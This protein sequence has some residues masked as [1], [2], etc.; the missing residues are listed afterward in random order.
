MSDCPNCHRSVAP[1][2]DICENCGAVL[3]TITTTQARFVTAPSIAALPVTPGTIT[4]CP[5]CKAPVKP[6]DTICENCG[7]ILS[8]TTSAV[9][10]RATSAQTITSSVPITGSMPVAALNEC[11]RCHQP[12]KP[13][14]KFCNGCGL[15][16]DSNASAQLANR[17]SA[18]AP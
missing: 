12:R 17:Q 14:S 3:S 10:S 15:R 4:I 8:A 11:P 2:D 5:T 16:Y 7:M 6:N 13:G 1:G 18:G 9:L